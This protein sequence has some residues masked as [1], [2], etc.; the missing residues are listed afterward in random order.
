VKYS[1]ITDKKFRG[2]CGSGENSHSKG[3]RTAPTFEA[4]C[5]MM[6]TNTKL[7]AVNKNT[8]VRNQ[9][10]D[11]FFTD[12]AKSIAQKCYT[13]DIDFDNQTSLP[14]N[15]NPTPIPPTESKTKETKKRALLG[16]AREPKR[17]K[18]LDEEMDEEIEKTKH[19]WFYGSQDEEMVD[20]FDD[21]DDE[22][23]P[24]HWED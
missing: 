22:D 8:L 18:T 4:M 11:A 12:Q 15:Y 13:R 21:R 1:A 20:D 17:Q 5:K 16:P 23:Q 6:M 7:T 9:K 10:G 2:Y 14:F 19:S 24:D 3:L